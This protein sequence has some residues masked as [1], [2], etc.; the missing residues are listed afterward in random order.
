[1]GL[2]KEIE[3]AEKAGYQAIEPWVSSIENMP[4]QGGS[5]KEAANA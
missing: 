1:L 4:K 2:I 5:L 3:I